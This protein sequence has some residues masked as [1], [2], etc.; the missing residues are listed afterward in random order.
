MTKWYREMERQIG[1]SNM[2]K[3]PAIGFKYVKN[4]KQQKY[5]L[6]AGKE[7]RIGKNC[8]RGLA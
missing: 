7:V 1:N 3:V 8:A 6:L 2:A 4:G 5:M